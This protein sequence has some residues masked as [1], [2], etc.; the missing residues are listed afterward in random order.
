MSAVTIYTR[1]FCPFC[2]R[3]VSLLKQK[4]VDF[5]EIDAG[6]DPDKKQE[7]IQRSNGGRTFPQIFVG[8]EHIGGCDE[9]MALE[10]SGKL[11]QKLAAL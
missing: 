6:M 1:A 3:A 4:G 7:M 8:E 11:D 2:T 10:R 9:M 5:N